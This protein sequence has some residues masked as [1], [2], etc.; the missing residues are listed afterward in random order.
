MNKVQYWALGAAFLLFAGLYWGFSTVPEGQKKQD[1]SRALQQENAGFDQILDAA[2]RDLRPEQSA[3]I[4]AET[5]ALDAA[6]S[7]A[8]RIAA[9]KTL[10]GSWY[11]FGNLPVAAG[12]AEQAATLENTDSAW[13]VAGALFFNGSAAEQDPTRRQYCAQHAIK[14]FENAVSLNPGQVEHR[15]NLALVYAENPPADN[16]MQAV[17]MLRDLEK[18]HPDHA[19]VYNALGR[20]AIKT[21]QWERAIERLEKAW[22]LD[23]KNPNTPCLLAR[24]YEGA[25]RTDKA[26]EFARLCQ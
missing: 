25:G 3:E 8:D 19:S 26:T 13:T 1:R 10:S 6:S 24:A 21:Q 5:Q 14:A 15:V 23:P 4:E 2:R 9:L 16:P 22:S 17:Q 20:L 7:D 12:F 11:A 18:Q